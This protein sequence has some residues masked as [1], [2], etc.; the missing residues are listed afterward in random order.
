M[1]LGAAD[2]ESIAERISR[3][4][5]D[6]IVSGDLR[7]GRWLRQEEIAR[8][9]GASRIPAREALRQLEGEGLVNLTAHAG[10]RVARLDSGELDEIYQIREQLEPMAAARSTLSLSDEQLAGLERRVVEMESLTQGQAGAAALVR[11]L[12]LDRSFHI[13]II[14]AAAMPRL[15]RMVESLLSAA[16]PYR[17]AYLLMPDEPHRMQLNDVE[18]RLL[19]EALRRRQPVEA[20]LV[21]RLHI[22]RTRV[23]LEQHRE[24]F[25]E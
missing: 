19:L 21:L 14:A 24:V 4:L 15:Q 1:A 17:R 16:Q 18:H 3:H 8:R 22:R 10:A 25:T 12:E 11:S 9:F 20:E 23:A 7:P 2:H 5:R 13:A 6:E